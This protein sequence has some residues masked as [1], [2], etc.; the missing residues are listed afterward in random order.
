VV[1]VAFGEETFKRALKAKLVEV[2]REELTS[3]DGNVRALLAQLFLSA[4]LRD[5]AGVEL[6]G[7]LKN[8]DTALSSRASEST[9]LAIK[10]ALASVGT[11]KM[12]ITVVDALPESPFNLVKVAGTVLTARDWS[13]DFAK[14]QN[15]D[16]ALTV[17]SRL[18]RWGRDVSPAWIHGGEIVA[19][20]AGTALVSWTVPAGKVGYVYGFFISTGEGNDFRI[21]WTSGGVARSRHIVFP[22]RG[23]LQYV[24]MVAF[25]EGLPADGGTSVAITNVNTGSV[26]VVYQAALLVVA[27]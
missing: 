10:K 14:L 21:S 7:Y 19:P 25:N 27:V 16:V 13:S 4:V 6:S 20:V 8:L 24:D 18:V 17:L 15:L 3:G 9:L 11:D 26:G 5:S 12:R 1:L 2:L 23:S 22:S